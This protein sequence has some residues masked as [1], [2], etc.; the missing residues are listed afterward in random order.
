M[1][2]AGILAAGA[3]VGSP[4]S[5]H[6]DQAPVDL[7]DAAPFGV[8][9]GSSVTN[10]G[11]TS[12]LGDLGVSPGSTL[13]G[14]PPG[15]V[16]GTIHAGDAPAATAKADLVDAYN[17]VAGRT[18]VVTIPP[19]LG[20]T[21]RT[22]GVY[23]AAGG[24]FGITG[25]LT[26]DAQ[27]DPEAVFIFK[28]STLT[29]ANVSNMN[30]VGGAQADN[31]FFHLTGTANLGTFCT[32]RGNVL[33]QASVTVS[34]GAAV[35]GR[36]FALNDGIALQGTGSPPATRITVPNDPPTTTALT[37]T[38]NPSTEGQSVTFTATVTPVN[39]ST[40]PQGPVVFKDGSTIIGSDN[41]DDSG[42]ATFAT[43]SLAAGQHP[44]TAVYLGG[45]TPENEGIVHFA[46]S[47][48]NTVVQVVSAALWDNSTTP[49][50]VS[51]A[52]SIPVVLGVKFQ[53]TTSGTIR[54][55]RFYK[56][57]QNT[58]THTGSLWTSGGALLASGTFTG[59]T[60]SGWQQLNFSTPVSITAGTTYVASYQTTA[61]HFSR[62]LQYFA[63]QYTNSPLIAP[64]SG[65]VGGNGVYVYSAAN[66]FPSNS[67]QATNYWVDVL[68]A[69][70]DSLW[71]D[72]VTPTQT[73]VPE[74]YPVVLGVKFQAATSG[75]IR[76]IR[77][78][79]SVQNTG[80]HTGSLWTSGGTLLAT[81]TFTGETASGWQQLNFSTPVSITAGTTYVASYQTTTG[82]WSRTLQYFAGKHQSGSLTALADGEQGGNGVYIY[83]WSNAFPTSTSRATNYWVDVAFDIA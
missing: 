32:F 13:T 70:S 24:S 46:P 73:S 16:S 43:S 72:S 76:G 61:G 7:G 78:Y 14:F 53:A 66:A 74:S 11:L 49:A 28:A 56:S 21:T 57:A 69:P 51:V 77:F 17:D 1:A 39:G 23:T 45:D 12:V 79:K 55:I 44:I 71:D 15:T 64:A 4:G 31:V 67:A 29:T 20:G 41:V 19:G 62:N 83:G 38:P 82:H 8:L 48:S 27:G 80:T 30:L 40:V 18:P 33:A 52:E 6:A 81:G 68:F 10:S 75:T 47:T 50:E 59:E 2:L 9:A 42:H 63:G 37:A 65:A 3:V 58:G 26:L 60:P 22:P 25:T 34:S 35:N 5:A 54:G 36:V